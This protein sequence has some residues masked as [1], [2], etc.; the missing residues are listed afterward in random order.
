[1]KND[2]K[3]TKEEEKYEKKNIANERGSVKTV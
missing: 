1:M 3:K 2:D